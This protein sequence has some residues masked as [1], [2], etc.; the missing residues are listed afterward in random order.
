MSQFVYYESMKRKLTLTHWI[1][2]GTGTPEDETVRIRKG[3]S[4]T[5]RIG[6]STM[7]DLDTPGGDWTKIVLRGDLRVFSGV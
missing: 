2:R 3:L 4:I 6:Y 5:G 7:V 1:G